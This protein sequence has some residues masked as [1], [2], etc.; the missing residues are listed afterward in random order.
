MGL[1]LLLTIIIVLIGGIIQ[2]VLGMG[3]GLF[4]IPFLV[5]LYEPTL[6]I[7]IIVTVALSFNVL[8]LYRWRKDI[9]F[10]DIIYLTLGGIMGLPMGVYILKVVP[11]EWFGFGAG[12]MIALSGLIYLGNIKIKIRKINLISTIIGFISGLL[13]SA[14]GIGGPPVVLLFNNENVKK[15]NFKANII[16]Y[17]FIIGSISIPLYMIN[18]LLDFSNKKLIIFCVIPL[19]I[20]GLIGERLTSYLS[21][22]KFEKI[23]LYIVVLAGVWLVFQSISSII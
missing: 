15:H 7:P 17:F 10:R 4:V 2:G 23:T 1:T 3:F 13:G 12:S 9:K 22:K 21:Q 16:C 14:V 11:K 18:G 20:G 5:L 19:L 6:I 8:F